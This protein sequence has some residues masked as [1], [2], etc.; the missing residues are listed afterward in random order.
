MRSADLQRR[1]Q[2][3]RL[4][5]RGGHPQNEEGGCERG[6]SQP[7]EPAGE[8]RPDRDVRHSVSELLLVE[9]QAGPRRKLIALLQRLNFSYRACGL[10]FFKGNSGLFN[11]WEYFFVP[12]KIFYC[13]KQMQAIAREV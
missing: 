8:G 3:D 12:N 2:E 5:Q 11:S 9:K 13:V 7:Q 1:P 10:I 4:H 6:A